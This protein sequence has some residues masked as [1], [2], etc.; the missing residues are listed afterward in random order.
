MTDAEKTPNVVE[1]CSKP[2]L[3]EKLEDMQARLV[4]KVTSHCSDG[5]M[6]AQKPI[7]R[8]KKIL[9]LNQPTFVILYFLSH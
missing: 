7:D 2:G 6:L 4:C 9:A 8:W 5:G 3:Y 1:C